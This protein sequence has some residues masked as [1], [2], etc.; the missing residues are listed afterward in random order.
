MLRVGGLS[1][2][3][4]TVKMEGPLQAE[5]TLATPGMERR[6]QTHSHKEANSDSP[7]AH[8]IP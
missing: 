1:K 8:T 3:L 4:L 7:L 6:P 2:P 5:R